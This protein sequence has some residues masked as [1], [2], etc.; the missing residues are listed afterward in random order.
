MRIQGLTGPSKG[1]TF[2]VGER[3]VSPGYFK[4]LQIPILAGSDCPALQP[5]GTAAAPGDALVNR[6]FVVTYL[7][8]ASPIGRQ[9]KFAAFGAAPWSAIVGVVGDVR[10]N[11]LAVA[12]TP[13]LY[14][15][16]AAGAW[17]DPDYVVRTAGGMGGAMRSVR[18]LVDRIAPGRAVFGV[19]PLRQ[20][21]AA[22]LAQ[23][24]LDSFGLTLFAG[25]ALLLAAVGLYSFISLLVAGRRR[26]LA[27]RMALG[28][29][30]RDAAVLVL[31]ATG[32]LLLWGAAAGVLL[33]W[34]VSRFLAAVLFGIRPMDA[35]T[36]AA[37]VGLVV[38]IA[39][40]ATSLPARRAAR[41]DSARALR[42]G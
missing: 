13:F 12:P 31:A 37:A 1:G 24:R 36:L 42:D 9:F 6:S 33:T 19:E 38:V 17:P 5:M 32:R 25:S 28:A 11:S 15:C 22:S 8:G 21:I 39:L 10:E 4:T 26:E 41:T 35:A 3:S 23:P 2:A 30:P 27:L 34:A 7:H 20:T 16:I 14:S 18:G 29:R 40:L